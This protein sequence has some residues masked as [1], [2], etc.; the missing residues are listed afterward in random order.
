MVR[1]FKSAVAILVLFALVGFVNVT[2]CNRAA[3]AE[4]INKY[5]VELEDGSTMWVTP[6]DAD[7]DLYYLN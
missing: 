6:A 3:R 1:I 5:T 7:P 4:Y 2:M